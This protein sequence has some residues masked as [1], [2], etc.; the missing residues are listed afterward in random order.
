[1]STL[2]LF[3]NV[4]VCA[5][6]EVDILPAALNPCAKISMLN[7]CGAESCLN[8]SSAIS[9]NE[10]VPAAVGVPESTPPA[11]RA[12]PGG[13]VPALTLQT[14]GVA[15]LDAVKV[16]LYGRFT[17]PVGGAGVVLMTGGAGLLMTIVGLPGVVTCGVP[18]SATV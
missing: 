3:S 11:L 16:K 13:G 15:V 4:A 2:P 12:R 14:N 17:A 9:V 5:K 8:V 18:E 6:R 1:M 7:A 10:D